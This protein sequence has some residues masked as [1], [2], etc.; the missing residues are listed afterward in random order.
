MCQKLKKSDSHVEWR[1]CSFVLSSLKCNEKSFV[2][3]YNNFDNYK[4]RLTQSAE[5]KNY[6]MEIANE[7]KKLNNKDIKD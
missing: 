5:V 2:R 3:I 4:E 1:N 7:A 6:F